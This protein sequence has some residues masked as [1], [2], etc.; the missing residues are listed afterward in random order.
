MSRASGGFSVDI[1]VPPQAQLG[2][3]LTQIDP[4]VLDTVSV[5]DASHG[6]VRYAIQRYVAT[7]VADAAYGPAELDADQTYRLD[8]VS[9]PCSTTA[10]RL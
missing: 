4:G 7:L 3:L 1:V 2:R 6:E 9:A 10:P 5:G 8:T